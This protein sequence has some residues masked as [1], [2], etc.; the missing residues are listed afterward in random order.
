MS[1]IWSIIR[2]NANWLEDGM[3]YSNKL[4]NIL[5]IWLQWKCHHIIRYSRKKLYPGMKNFKKL[6][7]SLI[8]GLMF[9]GDMFIL[10]VYSLDLLILKICYLLN[11]QDLK[12]LIMNLK[13]WWRK[14]LKNLMYLKYYLYKVF[15]KHLRDLLKC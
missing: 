15:R 11:S 6:E 10:K 7:L 13:P 3:S 2:T 12:V 5:I 1:W 4:M 8:V 9:K 14:L